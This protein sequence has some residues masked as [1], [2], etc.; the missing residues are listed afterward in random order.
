[1]ISSIGSVAYSCTYCGK[2]SSRLKPALLVKKGCITSG[3]ASPSCLT[4]KRSIL[5]VRATYV[6]SSG[7][8]TGA[9]EEPNLSVP[10]PE[11]EGV[12]MR[13]TPGPP[14]SGFLDESGDPYFGDGNIPGD[15]EEYVLLGETRMAESPDLERI[16]DAGRLDG[17]L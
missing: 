6:I 2:D 14:W 5:R 10:F 7:F 15:F 8:F 16:G 9:S 1:M 3:V 13:G 4:V 12:R 11:S 17:R